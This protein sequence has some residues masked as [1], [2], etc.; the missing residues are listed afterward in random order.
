MPEL[1]SFGVAMELLN[2]GLKVGRSTW[3][4]YWIIEEKEPFGK[5][6]LAYCKDG[7]IAPAVPYQR[8]M[9]ANDW[10]IK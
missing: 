2:G 3:S 4:G 1:M 5:V 7:S 6:I 8:D 9:L 10:L